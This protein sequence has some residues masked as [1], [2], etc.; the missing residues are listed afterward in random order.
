MDLTDD[1]RAADA[2]FMK[3][4]VSALGDASLLEGFDPSSWRNPGLDDEADQFNEPHDQLDGYNSDDSTGGM[5]L[6]LSH[7]T[8]Q[9]LVMPDEP[10]YKL[11]KARAL[12]AQEEDV[13]D[14]KAA[15]ELE[16]EI[17]AWPPTGLKK[18]HLSAENSTFV[19]WKLVIGYPDAFVGKKNGERC[20]PFFTLEGLHENRIW[21]LYYLHQPREF[22]SQKPALF[23]STWQF[24]HLLDVVNIKLD[25]KL[26]IPPGKNEDKFRLTFGLGDTPRPRFLGRSTSAEDFQKFCDQIPAPKP[27]DD[28]KH[29]THGGREIFMD[30]MS[31]LKQDF[32]KGKKSD[33][34]KYKRIAAHR[35]WGRSIKLAQ[36]YLG[37]RESN[38]NKT[39]DSSN[40]LDLET[41]LTTKPEGSV[42]FVAIDLEAY[43]FNHDMIT[44]VGIAT[45]DTTDIVG[46]APG[47]NGKN[48]LPLV[49]ARHLRI[50]ENAWAENSKYVRGC[51]DRFDFGATEFVSIRDIPSIIESLIDK[52]TLNPSS[53][54]PEPRPVVLVFHESAADIKFLQS[55]NY[56]VYNAKNVIGVMD[57]KEMYQYVLRSNSHNSL[58]LVLSY[59]GIPYGNLHNAG[60]DAVYTL[61]GMIGLAVK[62][63]M[64]SLR[65][66]SQPRQ[67][68]GHVP[69]SEFKEKEGWTS[70]GEDSDGGDPIRPTE[71]EPD[72][73]TA[74]T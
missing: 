46:V 43:E 30:I 66:A 8:R 49:Q 32:S 11:S 6:N 33:K 5:I 40:T 50:K 21:D 35:K 38:L 28:L 31:M 1:D 17:L 13:V 48:W 12:A 65:K 23:V 59:V 34:N 58:E 36:R 62:R 15:E 39:S 18:G 25:T 37:L 24:Q 53:E 3:I 10:G 51:A 68:E 57:T 56:N 73:S 67:E 74:N 63:R 55:V 19:P 20:A 7:L 60:N 44:E 4:L 41:P 9:Q 22:K 71:F 69:F 61:K 26:T 45:L 16:K 2:E 70:G 54:D 64:A 52:A 14:T 47:E 72:H 42:L 27:D 29:A